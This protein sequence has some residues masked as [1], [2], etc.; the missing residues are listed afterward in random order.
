MKNI[1]KLL[2]KYFILGNI[3]GIIYCLI[4]LVYRGYTHWT[5]YLVSAILF[6]S[7]GL[8]NELFSW[9]TAFWKQC[10]IGSILVTI[11][12]FITGCI[13]NLWLGWDVWDY[14]GVPFNILGQICLPFTLIW[15]IL[16]GIAI[17]VDDWLR[18]WIFKEEKPR[19]KFF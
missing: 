14:T 15:I 10:V 6:I 16:S 2:S 18:Y 12:E 17:I 7:I 3:G 11:I 19:Y 4:E 5:M 1:L 8:I 9:E 13:V